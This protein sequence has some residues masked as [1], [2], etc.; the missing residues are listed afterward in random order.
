[1]P[2]LVVFGR[3]WGIASDDFVFPGLFELFVRALWYVTDFHNNVV[4]PIEG[5]AR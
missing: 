2:G 3:R 1:M 4:G 5:L